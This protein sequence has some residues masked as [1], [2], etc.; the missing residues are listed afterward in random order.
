[1][2]N[3]LSREPHKY[4]EAVKVSGYVVNGFL[5]T[6]FRLAPLAFPH[7]PH[8]SH[9]PLHPIPQS[10]PITPITPTISDNYRRKAWAASLRPMPCPGY[11]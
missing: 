6:L 9:L 11:L 8:L 7:L 2:V 1:M 4:P 5:I 3:Q 10:I